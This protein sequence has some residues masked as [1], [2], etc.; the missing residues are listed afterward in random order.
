MKYDNKQN[1]KNIF[2]ESLRFASL[3]II[4]CGKY[5]ED[6]SWHTSC[7][8]NHNEIFYVKSG[9]IHIIT[10]N[11]KYTVDKDKL[12][13]T[14]ANKYRDISIDRKSQAEF[15]ILS[16]DSEVNGISYFNFMENFSVI[17]SGKHTAEL[18]SLFAKAANIGEPSTHSQVFERIGCAGK[19]LTL[20]LESYGDEVMT[21]RKSNIDFSKVMAYIDRF[22]RYR[23]VTISELSK[24]LNIS[25]GHF[26]REFKKQYGISCK[27]YIDAIRMEGVLKMLRESDVSFKLIAEAF[28]YYDTA[29]LSKSVKNQTGLTPT[30]YR[31]K[32][33]R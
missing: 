15:Y 8:C 20:L 23:K 26:R 11:G 3:N 33:K 14:A 16:F 5:T 22:Y 18:D 17:D 28:Q 12:F 21:E 30:G 19:I 6:S 7:I 13:C 31:E 2:M 4:Y 32:Y 10:K 25:E 29:S 24:L 1:K 27:M 9:C